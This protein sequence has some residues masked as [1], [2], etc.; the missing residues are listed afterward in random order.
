MVIGIDKLS[1]VLNWL[2][3]KILQCIRKWNELIDPPDWSKIEF[4]P[5]LMKKRIKTKFKIQKYLYL[6]LCHIYIYIIFPSVQ[7]TWTES[8]VNFPTC[9]FLGCDCL[10]S[11]I[12]KRISAKF[13]N[14]HPFFWKI[15]TFFCKIYTLICK[16]NTFFCRIYTFFCKF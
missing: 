8:F 5:D 6:R 13:F 16:I 9:F 15:Y 3:Y 11:F 2:I 12:R 1:W 14:L 10:Q 7:W 4:D